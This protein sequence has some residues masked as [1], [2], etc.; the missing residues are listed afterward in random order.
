MKDQSAGK[1]LWECEPG[2]LT[3]QAAMV[4]FFADDVC[5][6][7]T[8]LFALN[9]DPVH[10]WRA[11]RAARACGDISPRAMKCLA[12]HMDAL[13]VAEIQTRNPT[14]AT[15]RETRNWILLAYYHEQRRRLENRPGCAESTDAIYRYLGTHYRTTA[16]RVEQLVRQHEKRDDRQ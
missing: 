14:R 8:E 4:Q 1:K 3:E 13:A 15:Q 10:V 11:W 6:V 5:R 7:Q 12:P 16:D 9:G 2:E